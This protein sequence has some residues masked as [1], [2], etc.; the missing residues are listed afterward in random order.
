MYKKRSTHVFINNNFNT[1]WN[2]IT[3]FT[4]HFWDHWFPVCH[5]LA[6]VL[7][8]LCWLTYCWSSADW[9][10]L[11]SWSSADWLPQVLCWLIYI[12]YS[13]S[14]AD[15][16]TAG[17]LLTDAHAHCTVLLVLCQLMCRRSSAYWCT[18]QLVLWWLMYHWSSADWCTTGLV[19]TDV[20]L[21]LCWLMYRWSTAACCPASLLL[22]DAMCV[23]GSVLKWPGIFTEFS[24]IHS[25][26]TKMLT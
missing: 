17:P 16:C 24:V 9:C 12:Q 15:W 26:C 22:T 5:L 19:L 25:K 8:V 21:I 14:Y 18:L 23:I 11:Y 4:I 20:P 2:L 3:F 7:L 13:W 10:T 1:F 6:D